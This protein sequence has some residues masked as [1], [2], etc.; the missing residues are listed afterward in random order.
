MTAPTVERERAGRADQ[1]RSKSLG[2]LLSSLG[3]DSTL[4]MRQEIQLA[5]TEMVEKATAAGIGVA[6][7]VVAGVLMLGALGAG[8]TASIAALR[9]V[10]PLWAAALI[11]LGGLIVLGTILGLVAALRLKRAVPP[12]P[13]KAIDLAKETPHELVS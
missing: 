3:Q 7:G 4:L 9:Y 13:Q 5:K 2:E 6:L 10:V 8:V 1:L 11:T 12:V